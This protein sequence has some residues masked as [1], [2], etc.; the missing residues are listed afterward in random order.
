MGALLNEDRFFVCSLT[1][2][3]AAV[4]PATSAEQLF[5][6]TNLRSTD[7]IMDVIKPT[8]Q[9]GLSIGGYRVTAS[10]GLAITFVNSTAS[11]GASITPTASEVY[12]VGIWRPEKSY[13]S[14]PL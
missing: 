12:Q 8:T 14:I 5:T 7:F 10:G 3:P 11:G 4:S 1:L 6:L 13:T 2:S 9:A